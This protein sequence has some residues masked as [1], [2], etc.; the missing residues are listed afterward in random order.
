MRILL[1]VVPAALVVAA[2][3]A[4]VIAFLG[5][6]DLSPSPSASASGHETS[7]PPATPSDAPLPSP[8]QAVTPDPAPADPDPAPSDEVPPAPTPVGQGTVTVVNWGADGEYVYASGIVTGDVGDG[9]TCTLAA[10]SASG[11]TLTGR[12]DAQSTPAAINCGVIQIP[13]P[14][15]EWTLVLTYQSEIASVSSEPTVVTQP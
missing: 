15:G 3:V 5:D 11:Q 9:G 1:T 10:T 7:S 12:R 14:P 13:A 2:G 8:T 4:L 6:G